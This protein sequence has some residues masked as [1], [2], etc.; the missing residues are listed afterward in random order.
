[1]TLNVLYPKYVHRVKLNYSARV[2]PPAAYIAYSRL[3]LLLPAL[4]CFSLLYIFPSIIDT[5]IV[6]LHASKYVHI[7]DSLFSLYVN[8][9]WL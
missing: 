8:D 3:F 1:M 7:R 2:R 6:H 9:T 4:K 5:Q